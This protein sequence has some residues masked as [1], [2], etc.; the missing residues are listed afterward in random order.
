LIIEAKFVTMI[1]FEKNLSKK[2]LY[3]VWEQTEPF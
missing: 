2:R 1:H 3:L